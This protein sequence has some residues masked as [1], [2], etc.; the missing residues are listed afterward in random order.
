MLKMLVLQKKN[1]YALSRF[2]GLMTA[3]ITKLYDV[4]S[5]FLPLGLWMCPHT[6]GDAEVHGW[7]T[8]ADVC[9]RMLTYADVR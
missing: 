2:W 8:Y 6:G 1:Y 3:E 5:S 9:G 4:V 7:Q